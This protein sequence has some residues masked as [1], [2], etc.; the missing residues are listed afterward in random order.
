MFVFPLMATSGYSKQFECH[1]ALL[2]KAPY[3]HF[4]AIVISAA[5]II[6]WWQWYW[7]SHGHNMSK[8]FYNTL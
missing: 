3:F 8:A 1:C 7:H 2:H 4:T 6:L 5:D